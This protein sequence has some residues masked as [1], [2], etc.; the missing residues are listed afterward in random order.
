MIDRDEIMELIA[1]ADPFDSNREL[2]VFRLQAAQA[3][4]FVRI[5]D[6]LETLIE[7]AEATGTTK[8]ITKLYTYAPKK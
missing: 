6:M 5:G 2:T 4:A 8:F 1:R 3:L 7:N